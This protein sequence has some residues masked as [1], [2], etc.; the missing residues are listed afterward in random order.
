MYELYMSKGI[1]PQTKEKRALSETRS[2]KSNQEHFENLDRRI[3][4]EMIIAKHLNG[5]HSFG[6]S[7]KKNLIST[8]HKTIAGYDFK[9]S[10]LPKQKQLASNFAELSGSTS[11][12]EDHD[13]SINKTLL[14][15]FYR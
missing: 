14:E 15:V 12:I 10:M 6:V 4:K 5:T 1:V 11:M 3:Q 13:P 8:A 2:Q 9:P 7:P